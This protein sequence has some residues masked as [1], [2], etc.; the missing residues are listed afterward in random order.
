MTIDLFSLGDNLLIPLL[1]NEKAKFCFHL[2]AAEPHCPAANRHIPSHMGSLAMYFPYSYLALTIT[3][4]AK[5]GAD[6][7]ITPKE[8]PC[9]FPRLFWVFVLQ[10]SIHLQ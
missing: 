8:K 5:E 9:S 2:F 10:G 3:T 6:A 7:F 4:A 1:F